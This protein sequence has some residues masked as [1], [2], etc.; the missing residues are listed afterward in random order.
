MRQRRRCRWTCPELAWAQWAWRRRKPY[1]SSWVRIL[2]RLKLHA[3]IHRY[4]SHVVCHHC[5]RVITGNICMKWH[6]NEYFYSI[7]TSSSSSTPINITKRTKHWPWDFDCSIAHRFTLTRWTLGMPFITR[8][9]AVYLDPMSLLL[10][11]WPV[12]SID[13]SMWRW[14]SAREY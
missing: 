1:R 8:P 4:Y 14:V 7:T 11:N 3:G 5:R 12:H 13:R 10:L 2:A 6:R 9:R